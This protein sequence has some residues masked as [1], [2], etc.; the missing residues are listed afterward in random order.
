MGKVGAPPQRPAPASLG[1]HASQHPAA[2]AAPS[3]QM[4][5]HFHCSALAPVRSTFAPIRSTLSL[6]Q[7]DEI[8]GTIQEVYFTVKPS[9][10]V[11]AASFKVSIFSLRSFSPPSPHPRPHHPRRCFRPLP[12]SRRRSRRHHPRSCTRPRPRTHHRPLARTPPPPHPNTTTTHHPHLHTPTRTPHTGPCGAPSL[13]ARHR[14][15]LAPARR[16]KVGDK[17]YISPEKLLPLQRFLPQPKGAGGGKG[18]GMGGKGKGKGKG[19]DS[20]KGKGALL[21][22]PRAVSTFAST[23]A[24]ARVP[25]GRQGL[26]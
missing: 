16:V 9:E 20:G 4:L 13:Y 12:L 26:W 5:L 8:F 22:P 15:E 1:S 11:T 19:K 3:T 23:H 21:P 7:V 6:V 14:S 18:K 10:G 2:A 17:L 25:I 24:R